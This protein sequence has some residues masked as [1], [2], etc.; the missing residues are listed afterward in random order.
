M[1]YPKFY[2]GTVD[3]ETGE[4]YDGR[5]KPLAPMPPEVKARRRA[6][7]KDARQARKKNR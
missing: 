5:V 4:L 1:K 2:G 3:P 7:A 6:K